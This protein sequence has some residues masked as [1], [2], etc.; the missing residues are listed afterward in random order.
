MRLLWQGRQL[1]VV[2]VVIALGCSPTP[3]PVETTSSSVEELNELA[4]IL[5]ATGNGGH[6][7]RRA[8]DLTKFE[9]TFPV[10]CSAVKSGRI[11]LIWGATVA[12][13]GD[14]S[15]TAQVV[16]YQKSTPTEGGFVLLQNGQVVQMTA[17]EF[18]SAPKAK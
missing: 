6:S 18:A 12:G 15:G 13:E 16:A 10:S 17:A 7:L 8:S 3:Q 1:S 14:G 4:T 5:R 9:S 2:A 11:V